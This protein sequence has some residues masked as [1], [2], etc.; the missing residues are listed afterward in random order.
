LK[1]AIAKDPTNTVY[2]NHFTYQGSQELMQ[3]IWTATE[4]NSSL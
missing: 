2:I 3:D 4:R 1:R